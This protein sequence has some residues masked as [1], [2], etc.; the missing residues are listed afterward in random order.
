[1][2]SEN[3]LVVTIEGVKDGTTTLSVA[4]GEATAQVKIKVKITEGTCGKNLTWKRKGTL[5]T[6]KGTGKMKDYSYRGFFFGKRNITKIIISSGVTSIGNHAFEELSKL[7]SVKISTTVRTIGK[8]AFGG[9]DSLKSITIPKSVHKIG[10]GAFEDCDK[11]KT[12]KILNKNCKIN[13][14]RPFGYTYDVDMVKEKISWKLIP[15]IKIYAPKGSTAEKYAK[16]HKI[17]F[18]KLG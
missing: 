3:A 5:L 18:V 12:V 11:L 13:G 8:D 15:G 10:N 9:C 7:K 14:S 17:P 4:V 6:I 16:K 2:L 1:M